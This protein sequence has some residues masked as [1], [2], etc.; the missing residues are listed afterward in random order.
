MEISNSLDFFGNV[1]ALA[2]VTWKILYDK[3]WNQ[4]RFLREFKV[5]DELEALRRKRDRSSNAT[6]ITFALLAVSY[7]MFLLEAMK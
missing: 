4:R 1:I 3:R 7:I 6:L 5:L 2:A